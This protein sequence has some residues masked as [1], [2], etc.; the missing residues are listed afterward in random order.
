MNFACANTVGGLLSLTMDRLDTL[1]A[2]VAVVGPTFIGVGVS[3]AGSGVAAGEFVAARV[4]VILAAVALAITSVLW[5]LTTDHPIWWRLVVGIF[6]GV[7]V[8]AAAPEANR[9]VSFRQ[10]QAAILL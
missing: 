1:W 10:Q 7:V 4:L 5:L 2:V 3:L 6:T 9:W 8:F